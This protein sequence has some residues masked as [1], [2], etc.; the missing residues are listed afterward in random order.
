MLCRERVALYGEKPC[1]VHKK[2]VGENAEFLTLN[3]TV[4]ILTTKL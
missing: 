4:N 2:S 1:K 3:P